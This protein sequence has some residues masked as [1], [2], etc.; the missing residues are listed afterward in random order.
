MSLFSSQN[1]V[2]FKPQ[3]FSKHIRW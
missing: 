1:L 3:K 2:L